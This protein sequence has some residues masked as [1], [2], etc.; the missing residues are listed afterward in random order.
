VEFPEVTRIFGTTFGR[1]IASQRT[2]ENAGF[3]L[4]AK[5]EGTLI[6]NGRMEDEWIYAVRRSV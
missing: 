3:T 1:N 2:M 5:L 6:K 4:E